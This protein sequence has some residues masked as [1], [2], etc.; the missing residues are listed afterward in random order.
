MT[1]ELE[2]LWLNAF[3]AFPD[4]QPL[5]KLLRSDTPMPSGARKVLAELLSPDDPPID[6]FV[7]EPKVNTEF[8]KMIRKYSAVGD[9]VLQTNAGNSSETAAEEAGAKQNV[10]GRQVFRY[11]KEKIPERLYKR[12]KGDDA[13]DH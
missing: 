12:L 2:D 11:F 8:D 13:G 5:V 3:A 6:R 4:V 7:L 1:Y 10:T 9:Y